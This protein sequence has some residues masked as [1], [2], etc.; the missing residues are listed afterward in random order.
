VNSTKKLNA[1][2]QLLHK[3][4][5]FCKEITLVE[6]N[7]VGNIDQ[8]FPLIIEGETTQW[9]LQKVLMQLAHPEQEECSFFMQLID[10]EQEAG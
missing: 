5:T 10:I 4:A 9:T 3:Q 6:N 2:D 1:L 8:E 7:Y